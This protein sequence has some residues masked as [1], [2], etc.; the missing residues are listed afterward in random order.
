[1]NVQR[2]HYLAALLLS[3]L[4]VNVVIYCMYPPRALI[5]A[6]RIEAPS[7]ELV[8]VVIAALPEIP[9]LR[10]Y[11]S[12]V[13]EVSQIRE[14]VENLSSGRTKI[15]S[16]TAGY[17]YFAEEFVRQTGIDYPESIHSTPFP[18]KFG[19]NEDNLENFDMIGML[20]KSREIEQQSAA[21]FQSL[22]LAVIAVGFVIQ[23]VASILSTL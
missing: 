23:L 9:Y 22:G 2:R 20:R 8:G 12:G 11:T 18:T 6:L 13:K 4:L 14:V 17:D 19:V 1:M 7:I 5:S 3:V 21:W 15:D 16:N 10:G